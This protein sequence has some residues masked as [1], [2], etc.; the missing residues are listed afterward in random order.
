MQGLLGWVSNPDHS[1]RDK[2][3]FPVKDIIP[4]YNNHMR[5]IVILEKCYDC[6]RAIEKT[7]WK[8]K[9]SLSPCLFSFDMFFTSIR[10]V[11]HKMVSERSIVSV[12]EI[13]FHRLMSLILTASAISPAPRW[14]SRGLCDCIYISVVTLAAW[15]HPSQTLDRLSWSQR[16]CTLR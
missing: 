6:D 11:F 10:V 4:S 13:Y 8:N 14:K 2:D 9:C 5:I 7:F 3:I 1:R 12:C 15:G 16:H